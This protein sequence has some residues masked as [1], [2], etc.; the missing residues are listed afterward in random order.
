MVVKREILICIYSFEKIIFYFFKKYNRI[1]ISWKIN[2][3]IKYKDFDWFFKVKIEYSI[4][5]FN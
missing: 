1:V 5:F 4:M 3:E 2:W